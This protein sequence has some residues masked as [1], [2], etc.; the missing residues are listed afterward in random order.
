VSKWYMNMEGDLRNDDWEHTAD[1]DYR[2]KGCDYSP[3]DCDL[4]LPNGIRTSQEEIDKSLR[5]LA[6]TGIV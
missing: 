3:I 2:P 5:Y 6:I 4:I 1:G